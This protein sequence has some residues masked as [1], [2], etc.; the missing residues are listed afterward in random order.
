MK[1]EI[2]GTFL[3]S[4]GNSSFKNFGTVEKNSTE[5]IDDSY[6]LVIEDSD[7]HTGYLD[8]FATTNDEFHF[9]VKT[10]QPLISTQNDNNLYI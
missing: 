3:E 6:I 10:Y 7:A 5:V 4:V 8:K 2:N 1:F 9:G